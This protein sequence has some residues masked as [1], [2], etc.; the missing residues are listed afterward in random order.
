MANHASWTHL[1]DWSLFKTFILPEE[2]D[3]LFG[4]LFEV[5][6]IIAL[7]A[8]VDR[9]GACLE[10]DIL[11][12]FEDSCV[13][14]LF[15]SMQLI[16]LCALSRDQDQPPQASTQS[17]KKLILNTNWLRTLLLIESN[18]ARFR[19]EAATWLFR[20]CVLE[21]PKV[22]GDQD[23]PC[24]LNIILTEL[25][26]SLEIIVQLKP[27]DKIFNCKEYFLLMSNLI[28][29]LPDGADKPIDLQ[30]LVHFVG[31]ELKRRRY[32]EVA[33]A[34]GTF[35]EDDVLIGLLGMA[36]AILKQ[37]QTCFVA[38]RG[39]Q[40]FVELVQTPCLTF[41]DELFDYLFKISSQ[42]TIAVGQM[43]C[44]QVARSPKCRSAQSRALC[45]DLL[46][47]L[48]RSNLDNYKYL[49][50]KLIGLHKTLTTTAVAAVT[51]QSTPSAGK[52]LFSYLN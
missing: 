43:N 34:S 45:F 4:T 13:E 27:G 18:S 15:Y 5:Q 35:A 41:I 38:P 26:E 14:L 31:D 48:S 42:S 2:P 22:T 17:I 10:L 52:K 19:R 49:N 16:T 24:L 12:T 28:L 46:I 32:Y 50:Q 33:T 25:L 1:I 44:Q 47:E 37:Q 9:G 39:S 20:L 51:T 8:P 21:R 36:L 7:L 3:T 11:N 30:R 40:V 23:A 29:Q 6:T